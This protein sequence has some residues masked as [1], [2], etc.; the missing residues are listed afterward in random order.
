[1]P[2]PGA[3]RACISRTASCRTRCGSDGRSL[4]FYTY[5]LEALALAYRPR[6]H[7]A[8]VLGLGAGIVPMRLAGRGVAVEV[9]EIDPASLAAAT[10]IFGY[11]P[12]RARVHLADARTYLRA[13]RPRA[14]TSWSWTS[15]TATERRT[16]SSRAISSAT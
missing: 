9:V 4:S 12:A 16:T 15:S 8:L 5:A 6:L 14:T 10:R 11:E 7:S 13:L 2:A 3:S 1:M